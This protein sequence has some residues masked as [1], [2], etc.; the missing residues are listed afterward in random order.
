[1]LLVCLAKSRKYGG[2]CVAGVEVVPNGDDFRV[3]YD[4]GEPRWIRPVA[5]TAHGEV[6]EHLVERVSLLDVVDFP[7]LTPAPEGYQ[8]ENHRLG[9][10]APQVIGSFPMCYSELRKMAC[11][12]PPPIFG[13]AG[14][15]V[16]AEQIG[17]LDHS[18]LLIRVDDA[19]F[20]RMEKGDGKR[21]LRVTFQYHSQP[22]DLPITDP[23]FERRF[24]TSGREGLG[25]SLCFLT[26]SLGV[27]FEG[28]HYKLVAGVFLC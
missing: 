23:D 25:F 28:Q 6:P 13:N 17:V 15:S 27:P 1:M 8:S 7:D 5:N 26:I 3:V 19:K 12:R 20:R 4:R 21:Q 10:S 11:R 22:H 9:R 16:P 24:D 2:R 18:L 14:R